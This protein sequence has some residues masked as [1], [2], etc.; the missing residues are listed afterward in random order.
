MLWPFFKD[1]TPNHVTRVVVLSDAHG[2][3]LSGRPPPP[4]TIGARFARLSNDFR[5]LN[6]MGLVASNPCDMVERP[7]QS[8]VPA[9]GYSADDVKQILD[10]V[11]D[12][13]IGRRDRAIGR[14]FEDCGKELATTGP[15]E[16]SWQVGATSKGLPGSTFYARF[17]RY[18]VA[19]RLQ[20]TGS[21]ILRHSAAK[22]RRD[23]GESGPPGCGYI[24]TIVSDKTNA[25][26]DHGRRDGC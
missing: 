9:R 6:R 13:L 19:A 4:V 23:A 16:S 12:T 15:E 5:F 22:L 26:N 24:P 3:G 17:R 20:P 1:T 7:R 18:L 25:P 14:T 8:P 10:V 21:H 11:P 2:I